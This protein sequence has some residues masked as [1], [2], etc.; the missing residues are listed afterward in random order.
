MLPAAR[1][2]AVVGASLGGLAVATVF[3]Q[4]HGFEVDVY[5]RSDSTMKSKGSGLGF[6]DV[7]A[8]QQLRG[9]RMMRR[10]QQAHRSQ[11]AFYYGDLWQFLYEG[12][13]G[14]TVRFG[15]AVGGLGE[16]PTRQPAIDG[17]AYDLVVLAGGVVWP[18]AARHQHPAGLRGRA[19]WCGEGWWMLLRCQATEHSVY[20]K[21][22]STTRL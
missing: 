13:P 19:T 6:V 22:G 2:V 1:R 18:S 9:A 14:G 7:N 20:S 11:G 10:G 3:D 16:D 15:R 4:L 12:L 8:W 5:E 21:L 17:T